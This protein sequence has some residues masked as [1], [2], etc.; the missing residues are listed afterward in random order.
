VGILSGDPAAT[1]DSLKPRI[2][3]LLAKKKAEPEDAPL[4]VSYARALEASGEGSDAGSV[5]QLAVRSE[6]TSI[7]ARIGYS[8]ALIRARKEA[9]ALRV[10]DRADAVLAERGELDARPTELLFL[11]GRA[12][13]ELG[14]R[15]EAEKFLALAADRPD[16]AAETHFFLG[17]ALAGRKSAE[18]RAAYERYL[19]LEPDGPHQ[20]RAERAIQR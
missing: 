18:S 10:M 13:L 7:E 4:L 5:W 3:P 9:H 19:A 12:L 11:R 8:R 14:K 6:P 16:A 2:E 17:E 15:D 1:L 20:K